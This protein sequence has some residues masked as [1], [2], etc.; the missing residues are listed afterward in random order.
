MT[1]YFCLLVGIATSGEITL[2][3]VPVIFLAIYLA[4][5]LSGVAHFILDYRRTTPNSGLKELYFYQ[6]SKGSEEYLKQRTAVM[7]KISPLETIVF[8]FKVHHLSPGA[9]GRRSFLRLIMPAMYFVTLP[10]TVSLLLLHTL[11]WI[12]SL[13]ALF[14]WT[15]I[16]ALMLTQY[17]HSCAHRPKLSLLVR[18]LQ[19]T[20][21]F[22]T[23]EQHQSHHLDLG[24]D[25]CILNGWANPV[26]NRIFRF[27]RKH[28]WVFEDGLE[29]I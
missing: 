29:P 26:V 19:K 3:A 16:G 12:G 28:G 11:D 27:C 23:K 1:L 14:G 9:L 5:L 18:V 7:K 4:D 15:L 2:W 22:M 21:L 10:A 6:G 13:T 17:A 8:D 20:R 25:F 24:V